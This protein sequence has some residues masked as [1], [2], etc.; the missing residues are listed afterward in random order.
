[1]Q[2]TAIEAWPAGVIDL[3]RTVR[4]TPP[5]ERSIALAAAVW[6]DELR[7]VAFNAGLFAS[8]TGELSDEWRLTLV[9]GVAW[10]EYGHALSLVRST[11]E[12]RRD[13]PRLFEMLPSGLKGQIAYPQS[14][15]DR[16]AFDEVVA[17]VYAHMVS[18]IREHGYGFPDFLDRDIIDAFQEVIPWPPTQ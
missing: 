8:A 5:A 16:E 10:H 3:Y 15:R 6:L 2:E 1:M 7:T 14:Y 18:R 11:A 12:H 4:Q 13:G 9:A 17:S